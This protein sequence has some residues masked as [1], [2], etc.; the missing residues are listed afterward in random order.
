[1]VIHGYSHKKIQLLKYYDSFPHV[2]YIYNLY[3]DLILLYLQE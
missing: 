3:R 2:I 1:M